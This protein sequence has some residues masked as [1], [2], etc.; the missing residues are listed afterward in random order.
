CTPGRAGNGL[1][2]VASDTVDP[3]E[4]Q[5]RYDPYA[6]NSFF[7]DE[8]AMRTPPSGAVSREAPSRFGPIAT[9]IEKGAYLTVVPIP[10]T[11]ELL[12]TGGD[13]FDVFSAACHGLVGDGESVV[14][15]KMALRPPPALVS[16]RIAAFPPGRIFQVA[17]E[18]FG[19]MPSYRAE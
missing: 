15:A 13:R 18:G 10:L 12:P 6:K 16:G 8:R 19:M 4:R 1:Q 9:G 5:A 3:M 2:C 7:S 17:T 11:R 14:A